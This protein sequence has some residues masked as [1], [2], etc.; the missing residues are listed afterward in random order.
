MNIENDEIETDEKV[1]KNILEDY[2]STIRAGQ[3]FISLVTWEDTDKINGSK[4]SMGRRMNTTDQNLVEKNIEVT[5]DIIIQRQSNLGYVVEIK[6]S[7]PLERREW[8]EVSKQLIKYDDDLIGW[9]NSPNE[10]IEKQC[11]IL[12]IHMTRSRDFTDYFLEYVSKKKINFRNEV[13]IIEF[14]RSD[15]RT[16]FYLL[17]KIYG[18][19]SDNNIE[20]KL[21]SGI[22]IPIEKVIVSYGNQKFCD[23]EPPAV[24]YTMSILWQDIFNSLRENT[25]DPKSKS[26]QIKINLSELTIDVQKL[27]GS[28]DGDDRNVAFPKKQWIKNALNEFCEIGLA[29]RI[30]DENYIILFRFI[31]KDPI[32]EFIKLRNRINKNKK[33]T[34]TQLTLPSH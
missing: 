27:C 18:D 23:C 30:D 22:A 14:T 20:E 13:S 16:P 4:Y 28:S 32:S 7:L 25:I 19:I 2:E 8:E 31:R 33:S 21:Y 29:E 5:P 24:E 1:I 11:V 15:E 9:W 34:A 17:R 6:K 12:L 26:Y 10:L 3:S